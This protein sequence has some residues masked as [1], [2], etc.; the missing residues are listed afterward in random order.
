M[1]SDGSLA[2]PA[3]T[4]GSVERGVEQRRGERE[5]RGGKRDVEG[6]GAALFESLNQVCSMS[7]RGGIKQTPKHSFIPSTHA[8]NLNFKMD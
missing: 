6:V 8:H 1:L 4:E 3:N 2:S 5:R 7:V